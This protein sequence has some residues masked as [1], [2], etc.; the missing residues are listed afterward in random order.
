[1]PGLIKTYV[2]LGLGDSNYSNFCNCAK[3]MDTRL[4]EVGAKH[5]IAAGFADDATG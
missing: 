5:F 4:Q 1:M 3:M 2:L